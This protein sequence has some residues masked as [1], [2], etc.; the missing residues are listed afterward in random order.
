MILLCTEL[1]PW[2]HL[3]LCT[4]AELLQDGKIC[5]PGRLEADRRRIRLFFDRAADVVSPDGGARRAVLQVRP[6]AGLTLCLNRSPLLLAEHARPRS[7]ARL[8]ARC[9]S[10]VFALKS[11]ARLSASFL[12]TDTP[13]TA[14]IIYTP[15]YLAG[16]LIGEKRIY[17]ERRGGS[18]TLLG[19]A[20]VSACPRMPFPPACDSRRRIDYDVCSFGSR[21]ASLRGKI[22]FG[23]AA[24][25]S[26]CRGA[27]FMSPVDLLCVSPVQSSP[28]SLSQ[29]SSTLSPHSKGRM[30]VPVA[31]E[32]GNAVEYAA[33][34]LAKRGAQGELEPFT[35]SHVSLHSSSPL[36]LST[37]LNV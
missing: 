11:R 3:T 6:R 13:I 5:Q 27:S 12:R 4:S 34:V 22:Q 33:N 23:L 25:T 18:S 29:H 16:E 7:I 35:I 1:L 36:Q 15:L 8:G 30:Y 37:R 19:L 21:L 20:R 2:P 32:F 9:R 14:N 17:L 24:R 26:C 31:A 28:Q 10:A